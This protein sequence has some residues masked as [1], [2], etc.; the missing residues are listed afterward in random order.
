MNII[1]PLQNKTLD[2]NWSA[3]YFL[4]QSIDPSKITLILAF[5]AKSNLTESNSHNCADHYNEFIKRFTGHGIMCCL[6]H[7]EDIQNEQ[8]IN[9][10]TAKK[11]YNK[12]IFKTI[13]KLLKLSN[14]TVDEMKNVGRIIV[15]TF[16]NAII[17]TL[18]GLIDNQQIV[19]GLS[20][21]HLITI[22][23]IFS[24]YMN[25]IN[26]QE[27]P[28]IRI[29]GNINIPSIVISLQTHSNQLTEKDRLVQSVYSKQINAK[30]HVQQNKPLND[31]H[32][33][34]L[35]R[36][37]INTKKIYQRIESINME[38]IS[39]ESVI[40]MNRSI[41]NSEKWNHLIQIILD[42]VYNN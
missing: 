29:D 3:E 26:I 28:M 30:N 27:E 13:D 35:F 8:I 16:G 24:Q 37:I 21:T 23:P 2:W 31:L 7:I 22:N 15:L 40:N 41:K 4:P 39:N 25:S 33:P 42:Y 36:N 18:H 9:G 34:F 10:H 32:S 19:E 20:I 14:V 12:I 5:L 6:I 17:Y 38:D 1:N 11:M